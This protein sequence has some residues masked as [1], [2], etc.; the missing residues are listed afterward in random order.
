MT[1]PVYCPHDGCDAQ[2]VVFVPSPSETH[3]TSCSAC[4][5]RMSIEVEMVVECAEIVGDAGDEQP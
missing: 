4:G 1:R 2:T 5:R 3:Y